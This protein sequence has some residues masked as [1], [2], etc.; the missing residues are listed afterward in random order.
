MNNY[1]ELT[2]K[3][4]SFFNSGKTKDVA[5]RIETLKKLRELVVRHEDDILKAVKADLNK[6]EMEAKRAEVGLVL[7]EIDF[8][9]KNL[10][11]WAAPKEVETPS[12]H[13]GAKSYIYQDPYG[14][15]LVIAPWNYPF[16]LA[17]SPVVGAIAAGNC[18][19]LKPSELT[20]HTSS[21]LAKMF[22]ENFPEEYLTV[23]EGE[24]ETSTALLKENF[25]YIF[26]T[27]STMV[28]KIVAEAAAKHLTPVTL[29]LG[30]KSPTI[31][32]EDA[33]IEEA[34]K[35]IARG[36]FANAGQT[37]VAPDYILVQ[38]NVKD[39]LLANLKQ[40]VTNTYGEDVSQNLDF[41]HVVS[42]KHFDRLNSF[43]TNGDIVFGGKTD[44]SRLFIEPT[45]LDNISWEDNVMQDEIF[46]PILPVIVYDEISEVI[47][48]IVKRPKPLALYLFSED[49]AVQDRILNSVS[50]GGGSIND[51]INHMTSHYLPFGGVG[52]SGM[53]AY[54]GKASFDTFSHAKSILKRSNK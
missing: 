7:S 9:V 36:K 51:T 42:E 31:V 35:R 28:G 30:G 21:L 50:F 53:G 24:V 18:V 34:A 19:V 43:L 2:K 22:N 27:G 54:H 26:F 6:P 46:G 41:P 47:E 40:V 11:E 8:A 49:E 33:N 4:L 20:P 44:R 5:F 52:D 12:T 14:L 1:Q 38:R 37:C 45:V 48:A 25:D 10:A 32:H 23:V 39:E 16:Q 15:A 29:E 13:A 17:V 3:Q